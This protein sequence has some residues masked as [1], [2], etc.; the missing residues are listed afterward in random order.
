V[1][2]SSKPSSSSSLAQVT[3]S[4][5]SLKI[6]ST[7]EPLWKVVRF[8][9]D[10]VHLLKTGDVLKFGRVKF[11]V[12]DLQTCSDV[13]CLFDKHVEV[14]FQGNSCKICLSDAVEEDNPLVSPCNCAGTMKFIHVQCLKMCVTSQLVVKTSEKCVSYTWKNINCS[15]C[16][17]PFPNSVVANGKTYPILLVHRPEPP[18]FILENLTSHGHHGGMHS[19]SFSNTETVLLGR[20]HDSDIRINDISV[21]RIHACIRYTKG[22]FYLEDYNSKFG[23]LVQVNQ[24]EIKGSEVLF[25]QSGRSLLEFKLKHK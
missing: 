2:E 5:K 1:I 20:G 8:Q 7:S 14:D 18:F 25:V 9:K 4:E 3:V 24:A 21:S 22:E 23:T 16:A 12:K 17:Q 11:L 6:E 19:V 15:L 10:Q 13:S